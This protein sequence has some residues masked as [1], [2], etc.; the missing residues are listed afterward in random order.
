M[1]SIERK[2]VRVRKDNGFK[3]K[4]KRQRNRETE[5]KEGQSSILDTF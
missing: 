1:K 5:G 3:K 2:I 4:T